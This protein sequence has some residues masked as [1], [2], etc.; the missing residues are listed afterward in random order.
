MLFGKSKLQTKIETLEKELAIFHDIQKDLKD[1]MAYYALDIN[2]NIIEVNS[3]F[4]QSS[5][6]DESEIL[7]KNINNFLPKSYIEHANGQRMLEALQARKHWHGAVQFSAKTKN[8]GSVVLS[9]QELPT[10]MML[11]SLSFIRPN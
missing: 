4:L 7:N 10:K 11:K 5:G 9:N 1:E 6:Y 3:L 8:F 2:N